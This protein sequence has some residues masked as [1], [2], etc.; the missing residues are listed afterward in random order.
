MQVMANQQ[1]S[2]GAITQRIFQRLDR[3]EIE[4]IRRFVH[5]NQVRMANDAKCQQHF[6]EFTR[7]GIEVP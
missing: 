3:R 1:Q 7:T 6:A 4:M 5:Y 2:A